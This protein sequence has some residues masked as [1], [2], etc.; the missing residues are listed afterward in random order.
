MAPESGD[1]FQVSV[2]LLSVVSNDIGDFQSYDE[3]ICCNFVGNS[4]LTC[5]CK[6]RVKKKHGVLSTFG[7]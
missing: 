4:L 5:L 6:G 3:I 2:L 7:G 1:S